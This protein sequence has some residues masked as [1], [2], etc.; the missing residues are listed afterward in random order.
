MKSY[1]LQ[2][3]SQF[4]DK[5]ELDLECDNRLYRGH[6][7]A[8]EIE[9]TNIIMIEDI[10]NFLLDTS[11]SIFNFLDVYPIANSVFYQERLHFMYV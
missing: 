3:L 2:C 6:R 4:Q 8:A 11:Y 10:I 7:T 9:E 5:I 1:N